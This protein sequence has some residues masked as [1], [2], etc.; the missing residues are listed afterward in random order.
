[1][2][3]APKWKCE[4]TSLECE[5]ATQPGHYVNGQYCL[6]DRIHPKRVLAVRQCP[7]PSKGHA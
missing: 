7:D 2:S 3:D 1:M 4:K 6:F 5:H